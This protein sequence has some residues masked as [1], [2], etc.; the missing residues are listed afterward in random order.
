MSDKKDVFNLKPATDRLF[1]NDISIYN[2]CYTNMTTKAVK[3]IETF[4]KL[5]ELSHKKLLEIVKW[6]GYGY[7]IIEDK[8]CYNFIKDEKGYKCTVAI[9][10]FQSDTLVCS[11]YYC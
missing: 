5:T 11:F 2:D 9:I 6:N 3:A 7:R 8:M 10:G 1:I 4:I